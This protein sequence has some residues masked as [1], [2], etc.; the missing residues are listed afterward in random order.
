M[1]P[2]APQV[3]RHLFD[4]TK[5]TGEALCF[6]MGGG[7]ARVA[8]L[9][10]V[11]NSLDDP[12]GFL[13]AVLR[14]LVHVPWGASVLIDSTPDASRDYIHMPDVVRA[15]VDIAQRGT[16]AIYN[17]ASGENVSNARLAEQ[18]SRFAGR[19]LVFRSNKELPAPAVVDIT[20]L[21]SEFGWKP[22]LLSEVINPW[23]E[24]M[25]GTC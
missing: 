18:V 7:R 6:A 8:R 20:R 25:V 12:S 17:V 5:L 15:L 14:K 21:Q 4:L 19:Q 23:L 13:P 11:Y 10:S 16:Q 1:L 24:K 22:A 3:P 2:V 9:A